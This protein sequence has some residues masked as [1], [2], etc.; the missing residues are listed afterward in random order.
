M[1][2]NYKRME[3]Q[4]VDAVVKL[5]IDYYNTYEGGCWT[6]DKAYKRLHQLMT[7]EDALCFIQMVDH[8]ISGFVMGYFK[9]F[10]DLTGYYLEEIVVVKQFQGAHLGTHFLNK[11]EKTVKA[12]G[13]S[14]IEL[15]SVNDE[16]HAHFYT[17]NGY[18]N[19]ENMIFKCKHFAD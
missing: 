9:E 10:D 7:I 16:M 6:Y 12:N 5:Y 8:V 11:L 17:K 19:A 4:H 13:A 3:S 14:F 18:K 1:N 2:I 15:L